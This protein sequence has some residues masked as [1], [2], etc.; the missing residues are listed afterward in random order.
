MGSSLSLSLLL[1]DDITS[2]SLS[3]F[4]SNGSNASKMS[5]IRPC[6]HD[7]ADFGFREDRLGR[8]EFPAVGLTEIFE[9]QIVFL[10]FFFNI[11]TLRDIHYGSDDMLL[12]FYLE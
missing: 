11:V 8:R 3:S 7:L 4:N 6:P 1:F 10:D 9:E 12:L 2:I 5:V